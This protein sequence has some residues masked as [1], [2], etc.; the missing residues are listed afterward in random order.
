M[1][2]AV[3]EQQSEPARQPAEPTSLALTPHA[4]LG[5]QTAIG[6]RAVA[7]L[8]QQ[9]ALQREITDV[10]VKKRFD[11]PIRHY[12]QEQ[13]RAL[14]LGAGMVYSGDA[15]WDE[16]SKSWIV[17]RSQLIDLSA[18]AGE[19]GDTLPSESDLARFEN[20]LDAILRSEPLP[21][22][23]TVSEVDDFSTAHIN[24]TKAV[25]NYYLIAAYRASLDAEGKPTQSVLRVTQLAAGA[26]TA[27]RQQSALRSQSLILR[28]AQRYFYGRVAAWSNVPMMKSK[29]SQG[30]DPTLTK[31]PALMSED[32]RK[33]ADESPFLTDP[34]TSNIEKMKEL[35]GDYES[36][37]QIAKF[38]GGDVN[39]TKYP[40]SA[41]GGRW[42][43]DKGANDSYNDM[44]LRRYQEKGL[45]Y[46][47]R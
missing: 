15:V 29:A 28:D 3:R 4:L 25:I 23:G 2:E 31:D 5:L 46:L 8:V 21:E 40:S 18:K 16:K 47:A 17:G 34:D 42:W 37:K 20:S 43:L 24:A 41:P 36:L 32:E 12:S 45:P 27:A 39:V 19:K 33:R 13:V 30:T 9:R 26:L 11:L 44:K 1:A 38:F 6:N 22:K 7:R 35:Q 10:E 14:Y